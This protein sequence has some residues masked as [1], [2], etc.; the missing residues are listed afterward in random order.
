VIPTL[1]LVVD[2]VPY[3]MARAAWDDGLLPGWRPPKALVSVFPSLTNVAVPALLAG[4]IDVR[5]PGYEARYFHP[6]TGEHRGGLHD[7]ASEPG[8]APYR[9]HPEG[10]VGHFAVYALR[11]RLA[12][13]QIRWV[14]RR[15]R[16]TG[17]P[18]LGYVSA[19]DGVGHFSGEEAMKA[20]FRGI[21]ASLSDARHDFAAEHGV[22]P[23]VVLCSDHGFAFADHQHYDASELEDVL[24][25]AGLKVGQRGGLGVILS[26]MGDVGAGAAWCRPE[27][28]EDVAQ[29]IAEVPQLELVVSRTDDGAFVY[30]MDGDLQIARIRGSR[31]GPWRYQPLTGDPLD[32]EAR[33][34]PLRDGNGWIDDAAL[35]AATWDHRWPDP[36]RR[37]VEGL[38][39]LVDHPAQ[40]LFSLAPGWTFGPRTTQAAAL[41]MG[42]QRGTHG[43][44]G[45]AQSTGFVCTVG[46]GRDMDA[47]AGPA[48]RPDAV[49]AP[50]AAQVRAGA[51]ASD[52]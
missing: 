43:G 24:E 5:P 48:L 2:G 4:A 34:E 11:S 25:S 20:A 16:E 10:L 27:L 21:C 23:R 17:G 12:W 46:E 31:G 39:T 33:V 36:L 52:G 29:A 18:W 9:G 14:G 15:F 22:L 45:R 42:G 32:L 7:P 8:L 37:I 13:S 50:F 44:L 26:P 28:A 38:T 30:R 19:T 6:P 1:F 41:L 49:F 35:F 51:V 40:V 3:S 47:H